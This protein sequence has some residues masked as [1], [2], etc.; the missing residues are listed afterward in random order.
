M[1]ICI[2]VTKWKWE[3]TALTHL[4]LLPKSAGSTDHKCIKLPEEY[5]LHLEK[6]KKKTSF[7]FMKSVY[8]IVK[9]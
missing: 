6:K 4:E 9:E 1:H 3:D 5:F 2:T 7:F 8:K